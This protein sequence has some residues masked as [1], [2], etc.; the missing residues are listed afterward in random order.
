MAATAEEMTVDLSALDADAAEKAKK[1]GKK[2]EEATSAPEVVVDPEIASKSDAPD[3]LSEEQAVQ[4]LKQQ[5]KSEQEARIAAEVRA[6]EAAQGE[7]EARG[8]VQTTE[9]DL[10]KNAIATV[11]QA[12]DAL[13]AKYAEAMAAQDWASAAKLQRQMGDNSAK[14]A[15]LEAGKTQ[16][17]K[18]PKP[19]PRTPVDPVEALASQLSPRSASWVRAHPEFARDAHKYEQMIAAHQLAKA[20]GY[21]EDT[22]EYFGS[23]E[24]TLDLVPTQSANGRHTADDPLAEA[25]SVATGGRQS[26]P[27]AAPVSR[28]SSGNG[29]RPNV[30]R[31]SADEVEIA[32]NMG[33]TPEEYARNKVALKREGKL[34]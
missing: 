3:V 28:N 6:R 25:A 29:S 31:L 14:L 26:T 34:S 32:E 9:L 18:Q 13:E 21:K 5:L 24:K 16:L 4:K 10:V 15:Q 27:A 23:I 30:V 11:T 2:P 7:A 22:D 12:N 33:M 17:E 1:Q 8:R 19:S 20:R